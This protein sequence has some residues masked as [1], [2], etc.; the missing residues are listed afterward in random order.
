[1]EITT[2]ILNGYRRPDYLKEQVEAIRNQSV[3]TEILYWHNTSDV[4]YDKEVVSGLN[5]AISSTNWGVWARFAYALNARTTYTCIFDD[6]TIP[7]KHWLR[8]CIETHKTHEGLLGTIGVLFEPDY[9][10]GRRVGWDEMNNNTTV[11]QV[12]IVGHSWFFAR[13][14]IS[15]F[16]RELPDMHWNSRVGEDM[17]FSYMLQKYT[18]YK[19]WVPPH[20]ADN[21]DIWGSTKGWI[22]GAD[23]RSTAGQEFGSMML[24]LDYYKKKGFKILFD[25]T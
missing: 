5:H 17:H 7:G 2:V 3:P 24:A 20:P 10:C 15:V 22:Y 9:Q 23:R 12:D 4:P 8:N 11:E 21:K 13:D 18:K 16:W 1:M 6:D 14:L 19:T 25:K